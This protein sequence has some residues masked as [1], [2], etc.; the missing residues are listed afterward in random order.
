MLLSYDEQEL[1]E[2]CQSVVGM[3]TPVLC[4]LSHSVQVDGLIA[5][6]EEFYGPIDI[7]INNAGIGHH[8]EVSDTSMETFRRVMEVNFFAAVNLC[9]QSFLAMK[10]RRRGHILNLTSASA[11]RPLARMGAYGSSKA[12]LHGLTQAL[13]MEAHPFGVRV[14][15]VLP[16][17]V[18]TPFF[19]RASNTSGHQYR[20][21]GFRHTPDQVAQ[22]VMRCLDRNI[23]EYVTHLPTALGLALDTLMPNLVSRIL[24]WSERLAAR[25]QPNP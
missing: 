7:L 25:R 19:E 5:R 6:L 4:D 10:E 3:A 16:I 23:G 8:G 24:T 18:T 17:S 22:M 1:Q 2:A 13:R 14:S 11:R 15:E 12:A 20:P 9:R 21:T